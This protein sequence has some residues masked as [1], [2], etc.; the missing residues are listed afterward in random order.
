MTDTK[1]GGADQFYSRVTIDALPDNVLL[2]IF[3]LDLGKEGVDEFDPKHDYSR[4]QTLV[5]VCRRWQYV[6]F[7]SPR[8]LDL[9][10]KLGRSANSKSLDIWPT[11]PI[12]IW[13]S[14]IRSKEHVINI[15]AAL[16]ER[17]RVRKLH[18]HDYSD[19]A[20][21]DSLWKEIAA[22]D[23]P[24]PALTTL[25]LTSYA[26]NPI[27]LPDSFLDGSA[28]LLRSL[29]LFGIPY[30]SIG[31]LLSSTTT[32]LVRLSLL[33]IPHSGY[34]S[35]EMIVPC[36]SMLPELKSLQLGFRHHRSRVHRASR[37]PP[38][39]ARLVFP[40]LTNLSFNGD[41]EY[42]EDVLSQIE[43]PILSRGYFRFFNQLVFDT[44]RLGHFIRR[45][46]IFMT[47]HTA[48]V[49]FDSW[50][51]EIVLL[52]QDEM[53]NN[54]AKLLELRISCK[55]LDWQLSAVAQVLNSLLSSLP[56]L[57][58]LEIAVDRGDWQGEIEVTQWQEFFRP[59]THVKEMTLVREDSVR[60]VAPV[61]QELARERATELSP[62]L[63]T[64]FLPTYSWRSS[65]LLKE[66][67]EHFIATRQLYGHPVT[68][69]YRYTRN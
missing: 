11:L 58:S 54:D 64:L 32:N 46:E 38:P 4:W 60:F 55:P 65:G 15:I 34:I 33:D 7:A 14:A 17:N 56:T 59:F 61:L 39:L 8:R 68:I 27:V 66:A 67:I 41:I 40:N 2:E 6:V 5:H 30:P 25:V 43:T 57:E 3:E 69:D 28:P 23:E 35:P 19:N 37:H 12:V 42:L 20:I 62:T 51:V 52:G 29:E 36:L 44:P 26:I 31:R 1:S 47:I 13:A 21:Q 22:I 24:F 16:R 18:Y 45:T 50:D 10:I 49:N 9:V 63:Q 48:R 53:D